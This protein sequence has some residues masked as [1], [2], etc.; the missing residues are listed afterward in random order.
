M[1][2]ANCSPSGSQSMGIL[3]QSRYQLAIDGRGNAWCDTKK[4]KPKSATQQNNTRVSGLS[5]RRIKSGSSKGTNGTE[6]QNGHSGGVKDKT[7]TQMRGFSD[8]ISNILLNASNTRSTSVDNMP[9]GR[10]KR[11]V[12]KRTTE[13][14]KRRK[15]VNTMSKFQNRGAYTGKVQPIGTKSNSESNGLSETDYKDKKPSQNAGQGTESPKHTPT[16][17]QPDTIDRLRSPSSHCPDR[18]ASPILESGEGGSPVS[19]IRDLDL[20]SSSMR[21]ESSASRYSTRSS[22]TIPINTSTPIS[23]WSDYTVPDEEEMRQKLLKGKFGAEFEN[24]YPH[25]SRKKLLAVPIPSDDEDYDTDLDEGADLVSV[26][27]ARQRREDS[28]FPDYKHMCRTLHKVPNSYFIRH[29]LEDDFAMRFRYLGVKDTKALSKE[30][31][32]DATIS[33]IDFTDNGLGP[34]QT[35]WLAQMLHNNTTITDINLSENSIG[36]NGSRILR[37]VLKGQSRLHSLNLAGN[38][39]GDKGVRLIVSGLERNVFLKE[40]NLSHNDVGERGLKYL[41]PFIANNVSLDVLDLSWNHIRTQGAVMLAKAVKYNQ[42]LRVLRVSM[43]GFHVEGARALG[44]A[45]EE[46]TTLWE[47]DVSANRISR[48]GARALAEGMAY[49]TELRCL[50]VGFNPLT[51]EGAEAILDAVGGRDNS[52]GM[53]VDFE[54]VYVNHSFESHATD[55]MEDGKIK[56]IYHLEPSRR[57]RSWDVLS[58]YIQS[59][60]HLIRELKLDV[61]SIFADIIEDNVIISA[62]DVIQRLL[63]ST[64][65]RNKISQ[66]LL[67]QFV[68][69]NGNKRFLIRDWDMAMQRLHGKGDMQSPSKSLTLLPSMTSGSSDS[70]RSAASSWWKGSGTTD[71]RSRG[72]TPTVSAE[73]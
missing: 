61:T 13:L 34:S 53:V 52:E 68:H 23:A 50:K 37:L 54:G 14:L 7:S 3:G 5:Q 47:L 57:G 9:E 73:A 59:L 42:Q 36:S 12:E 41:C 43:N 55:L 25:V 21:A 51:P 33:K 56:V 65:I 62:S 2:S 66:A 70:R 30:I 71:N 29:A 67:N 19:F 15:N 69:S 1:P 32:N 28:P 64:Q 58:S 44:D 6:V 11:S 60:L 49:N 4:Q 48:L 20:K 27:R 46:N 17:V 22:V 31:K 10:S 63:K 24:Y 40:L 39:I 16:S 26:E 38:A 35:Y 45:L 8:R 72:G 18:L